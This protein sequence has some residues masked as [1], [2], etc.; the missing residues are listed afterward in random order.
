MVDRLAQPY[1]EYRSQDAFNTPVTPQCYMCP[2]SKH[3]IMSWDTDKVKTRSSWLSS[4]ELRVFARAETPEI[5]CCM[6]TLLVYPAA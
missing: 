2:R 1:L 4:R 6:D 3:D 5:V